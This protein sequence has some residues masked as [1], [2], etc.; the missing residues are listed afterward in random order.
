[1]QVNETSTRTAG[2]GV[3]GEKRY[4]HMSSRMKMPNRMVNIVPAR[5]MKVPMNAVERA[6]AESDGAIRCTAIAARSPREVA[7]PRTLACVQTRGACG[8]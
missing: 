4:A 3:R 1:M 6:A 2:I 7:S 8:E 5:N